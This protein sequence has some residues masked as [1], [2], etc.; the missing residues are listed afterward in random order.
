MK[1]SRLK[2][3]GTL[4]IVVNPQA[5][6]DY[7][8]SFEKLVVETSAIDDEAKKTLTAKCKQLCEAFKDAAKVSDE[9]GQEN[10]VLDDEADVLAVFVKAGLKMLG[11]AVASALG[12]LIITTGQAVLV[13]MDDGSEDYFRQGVDTAAKMV[14]ARDGTMTCHILALFFLR[15]S[16]AITKD[17]Y[18][19]LL[20]TH[21]FVD[22]DNS[23]KD[24]SKTEDLHLRQIREFLEKWE[25]LS[26]EERSNK[27]ASLE[28]EAK[29]RKDSELTDS[30]LR[31]DLLLTI[32]KLLL[33]FE[34]K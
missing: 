17:T 22:V 34:K 8:Q 28:Q 10:T 26:H 19:E 25:L 5:V 29:N 27:V 3:T 11:S 31:L 21:L 9:R 24:L 4:E 1:V 14:K 16:E 32:V 7:L 6:A 13:R 33:F 30:S 18:V 2:L 23:T 12:L 20:K 15:A